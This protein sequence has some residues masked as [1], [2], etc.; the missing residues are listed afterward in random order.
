MDESINKCMKRSLASFIREMKIKSM[1]RFHFI[2][3]QCAKYS[4]ANMPSV[5]K[6]V[7]IDVHTVLLVVKYGTAILESSLPLAPKTDLYVPMTQQSHFQIW[8]QDKLLYLHNR[9]MYTNYIYTHTYRERNFWEL[10]I[11]LLNNCLLGIHY[12]SSFVTSF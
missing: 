6:W 4:H 10:F 7:H 1:V 3:T 12:R 9:V 8:S 2:L 5:R 11:I